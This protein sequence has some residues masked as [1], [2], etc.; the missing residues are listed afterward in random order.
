MSDTP[1]DP[2]L[3]LLT[4]IAE[5]VA[6]LVARV[7]AIESR[8]AEHDDFTNEALTTIA[9]IAPR[10]YF[11]AKPPSAL[12][13][14]VVNASVMDAMIE[15]WPGDSVLRFPTSEYQP[16]NDL[17]ALTTDEIEALL[18]A[19]GSIVEAATNAERLRH[20]RALMMLNEVMNSRF[21]AHEKSIK[22]DKLGRGR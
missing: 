14:D 1:D 21:K 19:R 20:A 9:E 2:L 5:G 4:D 18:R 3:G 16:L 22:R 7:D 15:R 12:P 8:M 13:D 11:A 10:T 17:K 6:M